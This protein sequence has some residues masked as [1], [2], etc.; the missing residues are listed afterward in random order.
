MGIAD[1]WRYQNQQS[2]RV[3]RSAA[4]GSTRRYI[5]K[6]M[7]R[8]IILMALL[9][10]TGLFGLSLGSEP[11]AHDRERLFEKYNFTS[12]QY[13]VIGITWG[14]QRH[15]I[16][17]ELGNF[18]TDD[19]AILEGL[20]Q[21]WITDDPSPIFACGYH[22]TIYLL[23]DGKQVESFSLNL[24]EGCNTI[25]TEHGH[26]FFDP[27]K[28]AAFIDK[29]KKPRVERKLFET[30]AEGRTYIKSLSGRADVL[31]AITPDWAEYDG[32]FRFY[33]ACNFGNYDSTLMRQCLN[34]VENQIS[35]KYLGEKFALDEAGSMSG[36]GESKLMIEMKC[37]KGLYDKFDVYKKEWEWIGY[38]LELTVLRKSTSQ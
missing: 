37:S 1:L 23:K 34:Q 35:K 38:P 18:Y 25:A 15:K 9:L 4:R 7:T 22:Y 30:P 3:P 6:I 33:T 29:F 19:I 27:N 2:V 10:T 5:G 17:N 28:L 16:Q 13:A 14:E 12:G 8:K 21:Q 24:E 26:Y 36:K 31:M 20:K 32:E 11:A